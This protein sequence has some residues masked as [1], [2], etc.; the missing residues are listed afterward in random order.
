VLR[1]NLRPGEFAAAGV[2]DPPLVAMGT[3]DPLHVRVQVDEADAWRLDPSAPARGFL[4]GDGG[5]GADLAF[6][7][8]EP[9]ARPK[10]H[11]SNAPGER[12]D[13]RVVEALY[14][15]APG[16]LPVQVGQ[17]LD[18]F[19]AAARGPALVASQARSD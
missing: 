7:R 8:I 5:R 14:R 13:T 10:R 15:L 1:V 17:M 12:T 16:A 18:V 11:L 4:R 19:V 3:L 6:V 2:L 9:Q